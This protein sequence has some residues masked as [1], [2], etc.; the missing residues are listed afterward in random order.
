MATRVPQHLNA[1]A[2]IKEVE[3]FFEQF[4]VPQQ[5]MCQ[6]CYKIIKTKN[7][8][9]GICGTVLRLNIVLRLQIIIYLSIYTTLV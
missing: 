7:I 8:T 1:Y 5:F 3:L 4:T 6:N 2:V 9:D